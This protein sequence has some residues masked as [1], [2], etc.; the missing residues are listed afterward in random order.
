MV[1]WNTMSDDID[2]QNNPTG[3]YK[4]FVY[5]MLKEIE[6]AK[7]TPYDDGV[8]IITIGVGVNISDPNSANRLAVINFM[9]IQN[10]PGPSQD[11]RT[12]ITMALNNWGS[13]QWGQSKL[14]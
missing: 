6:D 5:N 1:Q 13:D 2:W 9:N 4:N 12:Q 8:G 7:T 3:P 10:G 11:Y 14:I